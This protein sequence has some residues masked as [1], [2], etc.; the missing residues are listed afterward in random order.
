[1]RQLRERRSRAIGLVLAVAFV[2]LRA[3]T[4]DP[5]P[6]L[7]A[8][9]RAYDG[10]H[11]VLKGGVVLPGRVVGK[12]TLG[13][14]P[15]ARIATHFGFVVAREGD[16]VSRDEQPPVGGVFH[17]SEVRM[18][19]ERNEW[20]E[21]AT[22]TED[23]APPWGEDLPAVS[24][25]GATGYETPIR[26]LDQ[27]VP[28]RLPPGIR[29]RGGGRSSLMATVRIHRGVDLVL[30][31]TE[32]A[33]TILPSDRD[34]TI[35]LER[36]SL[37]VRISSVLLGCAIYVRTPS[38]RIELAGPGRYTIET[39]T[40]AG[41]LFVHE[42]SARVEGRVDVPGNASA[43]WREEA[44]RAE[45]KLMGPGWDH[46]NPSWKG[47]PPLLDDMCFVPA[48]RYRLGARPA[49][50]KPG[51]G[52]TPG[53][54]VFGYAWEGVADVGAF[55]IDRREVTASDAKHFAWM[56]KE[57]RAALASDHRPAQGLTTKEA[58]AW[59]LKAGKRLATA[60]QWE[61]AGR[62]DAEPPIPLAIDATAAGT[63]TGEEAG[64]LAPVQDDGRIRWAPPSTL[65]AVDTPTADVSPFGVEALRSGVP[66][67]VRSNLHEDPVFALLRR[68]RQADVLAGR[69]EYVRGIR[70]SLA[71]LATYSRSL[72]PGFR[73]VIELTP[74]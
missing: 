57:A 14:R 13:G 66:E 25:P 7:G 65:A 61:I 55:L 38:V 70:G 5:P 23:K 56:R 35:S 71:A 9:K 16:V 22:F 41:R 40:R 73:C 24:D 54:Y 4:A 52:G 12:G 46:S 3:S 2:S 45:P 64:D 29:L 6:A 20:R 53:P 51:A 58:T 36:G 19:V 59:A 50:G 44:G 11:V 63:W 1:M 37:H 42:G 18:D 60:S 68:R 8:P 47:G 28:L 17:V 48:G 49:N 10:P 43:A 32:A 15:F 39:D 72:N 27:G 34:A 74:P 31:G 30:R 69:T 33:A 21:E 67:L 26:L 62:S